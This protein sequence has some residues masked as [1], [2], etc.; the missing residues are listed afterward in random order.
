MHVYTVKATTQLLIEGLISI[1]EYI[2]CTDDV[3][4]FVPQQGP[5]GF[6]G[7]PGEPGEAGPSVSIKDMKTNA[8]LHCALLA[9]C[10]THL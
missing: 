5:Q 1:F 4:M 6:T 10:H 3:S 9:C 7:P 8:H 2:R